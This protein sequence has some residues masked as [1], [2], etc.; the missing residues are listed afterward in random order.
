MVV[1]G[2][3]LVYVGVCGIMSTCAHARVCVCVMILFKIH[4][5]ANVDVCGPNVVVC[6]VCGSMRAC[7]CVCVCVCACVFVRDDF[8]KM[9]LCARSDSPNG[10]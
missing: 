7:V 2:C 1:C 8:L 9:H 10:L 5:C 3:I 4:L 6:D